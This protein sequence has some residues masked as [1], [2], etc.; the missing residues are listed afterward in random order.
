M[1]HTSCTA[2]TCSIFLALAI[3]V[4]PVLGGEIRLNQIQ[5][6]GTHNSY[7]I[8]PHKAVLAL[9]AEKNP[10]LS[11]SLDYTH[12]PLAD[13][14][15]RLGIR[16]IEL[17]VY[18]DPQGGLFADPAAVKLTASSARPH[19][20]KGLLKKPG[21]KVLHVQD[22]DYRTTALT[23]VE[24]LRQVR[25]WSRD[26]PGHCPIMIM[27]EVKQE[28]IGTEFTQPHPFR[29]AELDAIDAEILSVFG[30][31][32]IL[33]PDDVRGDF[34]S[35]QEVITGRGWPLLDD[36]RGKVMFAL[37]NGGE[38]RDLYLNGHPSLRGR[39]LFVS[40]EET[41]PAAAFMKIND[42]VSNFDKIQAFVKKGFLVRTRADSGT[43]ES[44]I[45]DTSRREKALASGAHFVSTDYPEPDHR[46]SE[47]QVRFDD[48]VI[49][50]ANPVNGAEERRGYDF[51]GTASPGG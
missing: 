37:D 3:A 1:K 39:M 13:Q 44:R 29:A 22:I 48:N 38:M 34:E 30:P 33:K 20:P 24:A 16:Q 6:I 25:A 5:V 26:N 21:M 19:D 41:H 18:A 43:K 7:H 8:A 42:A 27:I 28:S 46:F 32:E 31:K 45:N 4:S 2:M 12:R 9:V 47:Y 11:Q 49:A 14:F 23:L 35:L 10:Q 51:D 36:V 40:V 50:R 17:D 15:S